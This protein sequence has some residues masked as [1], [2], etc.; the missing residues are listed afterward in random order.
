M[1]SFVGSLWRN[2]LASIL[3]ALYVVLSRLWLAELNPEYVALTGAWTYV[4]AI[5]NVIN[6]GLPRAA[7]RVVGDRNTYSTRQRYEL[8]L[9]L[10]S[11][12]SALAVLLTVLLLL[13]AP[14]LA[15][16]FVPR[17]LRT[18]S[19]LFIR[20]GSLS[21]LFLTITNVLSICTRALD[22]PD[23]PLGA[24]TVQFLLNIVLDMLIISRFRVWVREE[25]M[26]E[27]RDVL[28]IVS[29]LGCPPNS[30]HPSNHRAS[31]QCNLL[32]RRRNMVFVAGSP[33]GR[34]SISRLCGR[35]LAKFIAAAENR[36]APPS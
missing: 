21:H 28:T 31:L 18:D 22:E 5:S 12:I 33:K 4:G 32:S 9:A 8:A 11:F 10:I 27:N 25:E 13:S 30:K 26:K 2:F 17:A 16:N 1:S 14:W 15:E 34:N 24:Q 7:W 20:L 35:V 6:E 23:I 36:M 29:F 3:P 19:I